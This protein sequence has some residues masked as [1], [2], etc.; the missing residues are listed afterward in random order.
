[1][2]FRSIV[3][4]DREDQVL[5]P[6]RIAF[7]VAFAVSQILT[8]YTVVWQGNAFDIQAYGIGV[9]G[10]IVTTGGA[11]WASSMQKDT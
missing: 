4:E 9:G 5:E 11:L 3:T 2:R 1:M 6:L 8:V 10:L 7:L